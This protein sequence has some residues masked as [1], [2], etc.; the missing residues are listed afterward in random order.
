MVKSLKNRAEDIGTPAI[1]RTSIWK[2][3]VLQ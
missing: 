2:T 1:K 3:G